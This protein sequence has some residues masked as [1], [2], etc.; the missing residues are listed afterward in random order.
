MLQARPKPGPGVP[1]ERRFRLALSEVQFTFLVY[2]QNLMDTPWWKLF[3][4]HQKVALSA[5]LA[6]GLVLALL[7][8][9]LQ[10]PEGRQ[11]VAGRGEQT[12]PSILAA[13]DAHEHLPPA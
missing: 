9:W 12:E 10:L 4:L 6:A 2:V 13:P 7:R 3:P 5:L 11:G 1:S 8:S